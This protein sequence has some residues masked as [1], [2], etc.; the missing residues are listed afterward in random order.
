[1]TQTSMRAL[2]LDKP[3]SLTTR[4]IEVPSPQNADVLVRVKAATTCGT[5]LKAYLRGHPQIPMPGVFGHEY[6]GVIEAVGSESKWKVGDAVMGVHS[7]PCGTCYWCKKDQENLCETIMSSK[8]LG[9][10]AEFLLI[11]G[12]IANKNLYEKPESLSFAAAS[13][14]EPFACVAQG[15]TELARSRKLDPNGDYL[16]LGPGAIGLMFVA[17]L[18]LRGCT[19]VTLAGR[20]PARLAIGERLGA[21]AVLWQDI[22]LQH[23]RGFDAVIECVGIPSVW[24]RSIDYVRRGG[25][26]MLFGGCPSGS[27]VTF[28]TSRLH[29]DQVSL[30]SPFHFGT[31]AVKRAR[32]WLLDPRID[33]SD[34][35]SGSRTLEEGAEVFECLKRG[36]GIKYV[37]IP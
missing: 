11:P 37:F 22:K 13:L 18:R 35:I 24:E 29:Y 17:A 19:N 27:E 9:S 20:N 36:E 32:E 1:M 28:D 10:F 26:L 4:A 23:S 5:D 2:V 3:G 7:A 31:D 12:R 15:L 6:S 34:L 25:L 30:L 16:V 33:F 14:L 21:R 8:V